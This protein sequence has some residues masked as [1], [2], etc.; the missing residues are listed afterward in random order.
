MTPPHLSNSAIDDAEQVRPFPG[1][2]YNAC[3]NLKLKK[4]KFSAETIDYW[5]QSIQP[6]GLELKEHIT[7]SVG[8]RVHPTIK[9]RIRSLLGLWSVFRRFITNFA[10][11]AALLYN[12]LRKNEQKQI[13][14]SNEMES[15]KVL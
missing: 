13:S 14:P 10:C 4:C 3:N 11:L 12:K 8:N 9:T 6:G 7:D 2:L 5:G 1:L 15:D